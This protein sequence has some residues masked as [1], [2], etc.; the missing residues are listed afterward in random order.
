MSSNFSDARIII[1]T[2]CRDDDDRAA[3]RTIGRA[4]ERLFNRIRASGRSPMI[5]T[6]Y[7]CLSACKRSCA[8]ALHGTDRW[9]YVFGDC[10]DDQHSLEDM[11][12]CA[13]L[14]L[15]G[16]DGFLERRERPFRLRDGILARIPPLTL[17]AAIK[18]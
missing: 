3:G 16:A 1:C 14:Y 13:S 6:P 7:T 18:G 10:R 11:V 4:G 5:V 15:E 8:F 12:S 2:S 17:G 9:T